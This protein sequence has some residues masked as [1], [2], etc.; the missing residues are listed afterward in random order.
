MLDVFRDEVGIGP[1]RLAAI[2]HAEFRPLVPNDSDENRAANRRVEIKIR[3]LQD[4]EEASEE[5]IRQLIE[6]ADLDVAEK[7]ATEGQD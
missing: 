4:T 2:G 5:R 3:H 1:N 7:P 6:E